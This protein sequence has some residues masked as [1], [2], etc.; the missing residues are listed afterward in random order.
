MNV[1]SVPSWT[2]VPV[3]VVCGLGLPGILVE[4]GR[5]VDHSFKA[6]RVPASTDFA[7]ASAA[8]RLPAVQTGEEGFITHLLAQTAGVVEYLAGLE[9]GG[10]RRGG[11][12]GVD[13]FGVTAQ[14]RGFHILRADHVIRNEQKFLSFRP[15]VVSLDDLRQ[16]GNRARM[17]VS[18]QYQMENRHKVALAAAET[19]MQIGRLAHLSFQRRANQAQRLVE[20]FHELRRDDVIGDRLL[21]ADDA[22]AQLQNEIAAMDFIGQVDQI[23]YQGHGCIL[24]GC[25]V[26]FA[27]LFLGQFQYRGSCRRIEVKPEG[28]EM[29]QGRL[30]RF[31]MSCLFVFEQYSKRSCH[32]NPE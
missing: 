15:D 4:I 26:D 21:R 29:I 31:Q 2:G 11:I 8:P 30:N 10:Q 27:L 28:F 24:V 16:F 17:R 5:R 22:L 25:G 32:C 13:V 19:P 3:A 23:F 12:N 18:G 9:D 6:L 7:P 14:Q 20:A 1:T